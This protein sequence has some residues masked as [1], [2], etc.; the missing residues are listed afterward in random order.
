MAFVLVGAGVLIVAGVAAGAWWWTRSE[1]TSSV[2]AKAVSVSQSTK[3]VHSVFSL[4]ARFSG[5]DIPGGLKRV[6]VT[7]EDSV[8]MSAL[9]EIKQQG[10]LE[11]S[12]TFDVTS[13]F[14]LAGLNNAALSMELRMPSSTSAFIRFTNLPPIPLV[15]IDPLKNQWLELPAQPPASVASFTGTPLPAAAN[16][17]SIGTIVQK[18]SSLPTALDLGSAISSSSV[19]VVNDI[20]MVRFELTMTPEMVLTVL[21]MIAG[22]ALPAEGRAATEQQIRSAIGSIPMEL[23]IGKKDYHIYKVKASPTVTVGQQKIEFEFEQTLDR[24]N[25]PVAVQAPIDAK[26]FEQALT[27]VTGVGLLTATPANPSPTTPQGPDN[28]FDGLTDDQERQAG[29]NPGNADT[30]G[31]GL[32]DGDEVNKYH[33]NPLKSDTDGDGLSDGD[34]IYRWRTEILVSDTDQDGFS[35]GQEVKNRYNPVGPGKMTPEQLKLVQ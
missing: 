25:E 23:W 22:Q 12:A 21:D 3:T 27:Q 17:Q 15:N 6:Q 33:S 14:A 34:E 13:P 31:D 16:I 10:E 35:D 2:L 7:G 11:A 28:D 32:T 29:T 9:P 19:E 20:P 8:D 18:F 26:P 4:T 1:E 30:D 5:P 24:F